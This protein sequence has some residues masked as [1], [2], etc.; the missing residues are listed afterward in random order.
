MDNWCLYESYG[1]AVISFDIVGA[2]V[3]SPVT[4][5]V[6]GCLKHFLSK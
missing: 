2:S 5:F 1:S 6:I 3:T 4:S